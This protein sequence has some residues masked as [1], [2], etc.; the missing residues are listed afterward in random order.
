MEPQRVLADRRIKAT[1]NT[2]ALKYG[3]L[4][5]N[6]ETADNHSIN[7]TIDPATPLRAEWRPDLLGGV[8]VLTGKWSDGSDLIAI[9]NYARMNRAGSPPQYPEDVPPPPDGKL[10]SKVWI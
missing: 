4:V 6:V 10:S 2:V 5:Y 9:P 1:L 7:A 3:P 8:M